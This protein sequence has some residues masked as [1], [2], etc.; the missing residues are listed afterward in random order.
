MLTA[1]L[2]MG[3]RTAG[4]VNLVDATGAVAVT[5]GGVSPADSV[6]VQR[7]ADEA[8]RLL[9]AKLA[10]ARTLA[11][12]HATDRA[13]AAAAAASVHVAHRSA[14]ELALRVLT[15]DCVALHGAAFDLMV[16]S[17]GAAS[18]ATE[19]IDALAAAG[20]ATTGTAVAAAASASAGEVQSGAVKE[21]PAD[22]ATVVLAARTASDE[23]AKAVDAPKATASTPAVILA[24]TPTPPS[25]PS[26]SPTP[27]RTFPEIASAR[28]V[29][30]PRRQSGRVRTG[31]LAHI[32]SRDELDAGASF[33]GTCADRI[34]GANLGC[35]VLVY[36]QPDARADTA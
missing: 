31:T 17:G 26:Q 10:V 30:L 32:F 36:L 2:D 33:L 1:S 35:N 11:G 15:Q 25:A 16:V 29:A 3:T 21:T 12:P 23:G 4:A 14:L 9:A 28:G 13:V 19:P 20:F 7:T 27:A 8:A 5:V 24:C 18:G 34:L 6:T 22:A